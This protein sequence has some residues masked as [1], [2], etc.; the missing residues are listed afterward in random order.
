M[1]FERLIFFLIE[2][3]TQRSNEAL[4]FLYKIFLLR[5]CLVFHPNFFHP[6]HRIFRHMDG[7]LNVD[8]NKN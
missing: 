4:K 6:L 1:A 2:D 8:E 5:P 3:G 7:A